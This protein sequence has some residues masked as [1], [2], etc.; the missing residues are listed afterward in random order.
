MSHPQLAPTTYTIEL[1]QAREINR[2]LAAPGHADITAETLGVAGKATASS[3]LFRV[4]LFGTALPAEALRPE[5]TLSYVTAEGSPE[6][7]Y[8]LGHFTASSAGARRGVSAGL[9]IE[10]HS[11]VLSRLSSKLGLRHCWGTD[12]V[13]AGKIIR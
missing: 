10:L 13:L 6:F 11:D 1:R 2:R 3:T 12:A 7:P 5:A 4:D 9:V 8:L